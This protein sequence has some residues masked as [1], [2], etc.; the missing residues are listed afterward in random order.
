MSEQL[1][2][3]G[4]YKSLLLFVSR[5]ALSRFFST[6]ALKYKIFLPQLKTLEATPV[7]LLKDNYINHF[8]SCL[9]IASSPDNYDIWK[10]KFDELMMYLLQKDER[11]VDYF[12]SLSMEWEEDAQLRKIVNIHMHSSITVD[13]LAFLCHMSL[14]TFKRKFARVFGAAPKQWFLKIRMDRAADLLKS[15]GMKASEIYVELGYENLSS[16]VQSFKKFYGLTPK[17]FQLSK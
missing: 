12:Y 16:F 3:N 15:K 5:K 14:S 7:S 1:A 6:N 8:I 11:L 13:E 17:K 10:L 4:N 2:V 9:E